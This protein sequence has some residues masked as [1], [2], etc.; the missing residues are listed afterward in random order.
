MILIVALLSLAQAAPSEVN[1][2]LLVPG[3]RVGPVRANAVRADLHGFFPRATIEDRELELDEGVVFPATMIARATPSESLAIVWN[4]KGPDAHPKEIFVCRGLRRGA[5][6]WHVEVAGKEIAVGTRLTDL[7]TMNG[8]PFTVNGFGWTY[9]ANV[10]SWD[11]GKLGKLDCNASLS[12]ALDGERSRD[13]ELTMDLTAE[14]QTS[15][16][17]NRPVSSTTPGLRKLNPAVTE[18][19]F[20]FPGPDAKPCA[21]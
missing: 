20:V 8:G 1:D 21:R 19:L 13:G 4:G 16:Y 5:C 11:G 7:E 6:K 18:I 14:E 17:G 9:G 12:L 10:L 2:W 15:F 3:V